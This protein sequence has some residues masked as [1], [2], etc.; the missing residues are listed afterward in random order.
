MNVK[1]A[2]LGLALAL[3]IYA[4]GSVLTKGYPNE[5]EAMVIAATSLGSG[6]ALC[7]YLSRRDRRLGRPLPPSLF[8]R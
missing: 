4:V 1:N 8:R 3:V 7:N 2:N 6:I 5:L